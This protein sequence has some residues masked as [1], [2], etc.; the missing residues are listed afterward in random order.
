MV[1]V[2]NGTFEEYIPVIYGQTR[3]Q[4]KVNNHDLKAWRQHPIGPDRAHR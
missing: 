2:K 3:L 4:I 1:W